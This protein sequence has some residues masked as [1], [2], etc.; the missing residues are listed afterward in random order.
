M[1]KQKL[2]SSRR[3]TKDPNMLGS[4][5]GHL[6]Q[7]NQK[8]PLIKPT[9]MCEVKVPKAK[10]CMMTSEIFP[11]L[12]E[13]TIKIGPREQGILYT[14]LPHSQEKWEKPHCHEP[15][16]NQPIHYLNKVQN[17]HPEADRVGHS[18]RTVG[19]VTQHQV[20][21]LPCSNSKKT[22]LL[23]LL[24]VEGQTLPVEDLGFFLS[25]SPKTFPRVTKPILHLCQKIG[26]TIFLYL[27]TAL[28][29]AASYTQAKEDGQRE[30]KLLQRLQFVLSLEK[31]QLEPLNNLN[32]WAWYST[33]RIWSCYF[34]E[35][36]SW[37]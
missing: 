15:K 10:E 25:T 32:T 24:P 9:S 23:P 3:E 36:R 35:T 6:L 7:F 31:C 20:S 30:V 37:Q 22:L 26:I 2:N 29:L 33:H 13:G 34:P 12:S 18:S 16:T 14:S 4:I 19:S 17:D 27:D 11:V 5:Q 21:I 8:S 28:V 1:Q